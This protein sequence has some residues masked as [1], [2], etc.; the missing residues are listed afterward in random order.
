MRG[1]ANLVRVCDACYQAVTGRE[2]S[3]SWPSNGTDTSVSTDQHPTDRQQHSDV[4]ANLTHGT[5]RR[6]NPQ[7]AGVVA[8]ENRVEPVSEAA[9]EFNTPPHHDDNYQAAYSYP[10][11]NPATVMKDASRNASPDQL[12][13]QMLVQRWASVRQETNF[14]DILVQRGDRVEPDTIVEYSR[15]TESITLQPEVASKV[16]GTRLLP[17]PEPVE[18][19]VRA[20]TEPVKSMLSGTSKLMMSEAMAAISQRV[21]P[22]ASTESVRRACPTQFSEC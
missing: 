5:A 8:K 17:L 6:G 22:K 10:S 12:E 9:T 21:V 2:L 3:V 14:I 4:K 1:M 15:E 19:S 20:L 11:M 16:L 18:D 7:C 13:R